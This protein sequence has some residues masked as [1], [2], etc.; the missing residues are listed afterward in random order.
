MAITLSESP[1]FCE[2]P[3]G[4]LLKIKKYPAGNRNRFDIDKTIPLSKDSRT[5]ESDE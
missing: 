3:N 4:L 2:I 1:T 5:G